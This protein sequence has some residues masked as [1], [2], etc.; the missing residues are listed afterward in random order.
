MNH[1][2][3]L[4]K[5]F[6]ELANEL[7]A[8]NILRS[9]KYLGDIGETICELL[10]NIKLN[11]NQREKSYDGW[12]NDKKVQIKLNNS[13]NGTNIFIGDKIEFDLLYLIITKQSKLFLYNDIK[14]IEYVIYIF[15]NSEIEGNK[16]I[17]KNI[18]INK[19]P[20]TFFT[21]SF[22]EIAI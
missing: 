6:F 8:N 18:L 14:D 16:Y 10:F 22:N 11:N 15:E 17:H 5:Q 13:T 2:L 9:S 19:K 1:K 20:Y 3:K 7:K 4:I 21:N 12:F